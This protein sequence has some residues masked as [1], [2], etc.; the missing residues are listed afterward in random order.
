[1]ATIYDMVVVAHDSASGDAQRDLIA[2]TGYWMLAGLKLKDYFK[3]IVSGIRPG[4]VQTK[5]NMAKASG[6][7]SFSSF[8]ATDT[9]T[10]N[11]LVFTCVASNAT[12]LLQFN[13]GGTDTLS[14]ASAV[15]VLNAHTTL[16]GMIIA[17]SASEVITITA[18]I[19]G[20][21]GNAMTTAIS[22]HGSAS[23]ARLTGGTN[24]DVERTHYYGSAS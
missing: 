4:V 17:T 18:L 21:I 15:T 5:V 13:V 3:S 12:G 24:G 22:A 20:E 11:G 7:I 6:T 14:A 1:M 2:E 9:I 23:G 10:V 8:V 16:D 19:P